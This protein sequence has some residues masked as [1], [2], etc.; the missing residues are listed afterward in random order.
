MLL[1]IFSVEHTQVSKKLKISQG[2]HIVI[3]LFNPL[4][5]NQMAHNDVIT[6][7][8]HLHGVSKIFIKVLCYNLY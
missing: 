1:I 3:N 4:R 6:V 8:A 2:N 7:V 5:R